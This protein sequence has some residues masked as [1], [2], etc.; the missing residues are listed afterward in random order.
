MGELMR[1]VVSLPAGS[2]FPLVFDDYP[3]LSQ[4]LSASL[5][6]RLFSH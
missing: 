1:Q 3:A 6:D 4:A 2:N 5:G